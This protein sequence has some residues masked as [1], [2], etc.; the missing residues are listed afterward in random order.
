MNMKVLDEIQ[1]YL[2]NELPDHFEYADEE[3]RYE[4]LDFLE[5]LM[6][7]GEKADA[8]ATKLIFK[9]SLLEALSGMKT[10]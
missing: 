6:E 4:L 5:R 1:S 2:E 9:D 8:V 10:Q 3:R 7:I